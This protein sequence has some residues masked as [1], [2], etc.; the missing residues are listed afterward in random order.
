MQLDLA[1][2]KS[3]R[4]FAE[5]FLQSESRL[6]LLINNAGEPHS[7]TQRV[8][9]QRRFLRSQFLKS[10]LTH[11]SVFINAKKPSHIISI[12]KQT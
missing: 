10:R 1:S 11:C 5:S 4:S 8:N 12:R 2:L 6:D 3:V 9:V 7:S